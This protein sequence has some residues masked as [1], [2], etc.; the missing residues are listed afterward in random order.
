MAIGDIWASLNDKCW[1]ILDALHLGGVVDRFHLPPILLPII[2]LAVIAGLAFLM[3]FAGGTSLVEPGCGDGAC[4][5]PAGEDIISCPDDC[6]LEGDAAGNVRVEITGQIASEIEVSLNSGEGDLIQKRSGHSNTF[7]FEKVSS[8]MVFAH[9]RNTDNGNAVDTR[10]QPVTEDTVISVSLPQDF[11]SVSETAPAKGTLVVT[12]KSAGNEPLSGRISL[13][14]KGESYSLVSSNRIEGRLSIPIE[15]GKWYAIVAESSGYMIY[16]GRGDDFLAEAGKETKVDIKL[17][18]LTEEQLTQPVSLNVCVNDQNGLGVEGAV[19]AASL[20]GS[21]ISRQALSSGCVEFELTA[22]VPVV[23]STTGLPQDCVG[24]REE[25]TP[26]QGQAPL[27]LE[28]SCG[29][30]GRVRVKVVGANTVLTDTASITASY[31]GGEIIPGSGMANT[32]SLGEGGYT[33]FVSVEPMRHFSFTVANL[34]DYPIYESGEYSVDPLENLSITLNITPVPEQP[35]EY[36]FEF[37]GIAY[38][39]PVTVNSPFTVSISSIYYGD[40]DITATANLSAAV[41]GNNCTTETRTGALVASCIAPSKPGE[42]GLG[43][44]A[45]YGGAKGTLALGLSALLVGEPY[46]EL[47]PHLITDTQ[48]PIELDFDIKFNKTLLDQLDDSKVT[49][50]YD[51]GG[52]KVSELVLTGS[53]GWYSLAVSTPYPGDHR[54]EI[55]LT[56]VRGQTL[57]EQNFTVLFTSSA[58]TG[59]TVASLAR[60]VIL[61]PSEQF[62]VYA[63]IKKGS[64]EV[65]SL[66]NV[67]S[68]LKGESAQMAWDGGLHAYAA[69]FTAPS[70]EGIYM[71]PITLGSQAMRTQEIY[72]VDIS[73]PKSPACVINSCENVLDARACSYEFREKGMH[74]ETAIINCVKAS[75]FVASDVY[76]CLSP[77]AGRGD[78]K[79]DC[80][81]DSSDPP[82]MSKVLAKMPSQESL[83][84]YKYCGDMDNDGDVDN[85]DLTCLTNVIAS[86]WQGD[87]GT[88][89]CP[90]NM[91]G[92]FCTDILYGLPGDFDGNSQFTSADSAIMVKI[93]TAAMAGVTTPDTLLDV[94]DFDQNGR[95]D[96]ADKSCLYSIVGGGHIDSDCLEVYGFGCG[97]A[98]GDLNE[99]GTLDSMDEMLLKWIING[100]VDP[101]GCADLNGDDLVTEEDL[102]CLRG[103]MSGDQ[104]TI[105]EYCTNCIDEQTEFG[106][107]GAEF[108]NDGYDNNCNGEIDERCVCKDGTTCDKPWDIDGMIETNDG[109]F[110]F[111]TSWAGWGW[112][113]YTNEYPTSSSVIDIYSE[114][115]EASDFGKSMYNSCDESAICF[116]LCNGD[117]WW[118]RNPE[119][120]VELDSDSLTMQ[121]DEFPIPYDTSQFSCGA[122]LATIGVT[123]TGGF[124]CE[125]SRGETGRQDCT[126]DGSSGGCTVGSATHTLMT[127]TYDCQACCYSTDVCP[128]YDYPD[129]DQFFDDQPDCSL[130]LGDCS[131]FNGCKSCWHNPSVYGLITTTATDAN[132]PRNKA[133]VGYDFNSSKYKDCLERCMKGV[134]GCDGTA[135]ISDTATSAGTFALSSGATLT[136]P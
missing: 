66:I 93:V 33:E 45:E 4:D 133:A 28:V 21:A 14:L 60:P 9:V 48:S 20:T 37:S 117:L 136:I 82:L 109:A 12:L 34:S 100:R 24:A 108:C 46:F 18:A 105:D 56:E 135:T 15:A 8:S 63:T 67:Y 103:I 98:L 51:D 13:Y 32:L 40:T 81:L 91:K 10:P 41:A 113:P 72:V 104:A 86:K 94:A 115:V 124:C 69:S 77:D 16:D 95:I 27:T 57:Y 112:V 64:S 62:T 83:N 44:I 17:E 107:Y 49:I 106:R 52:L 92:G 126:I 3:L 68:D 54:A 1:P 11:F 38:P 129:F 53:N 75:L 74:T 118:Y 22:G 39:N 7:T 23:F 130:R 116:G 58:A 19:E 42:Y 120:G 78:W 85:D 2:L 89:V 121:F 87:N 29:A 101:V 35:P 65:A 84:E 111:H 132:C 110:C 96:Q 97:G 71:V 26:E 31:A 122:A 134:P 127:T 59:L 114:C 79:H 88:G 47:T 5:S 119:E 128:G 6:L 50:Y 70:S 55:K 36:E 125:P 61:K 80:K 30:A 102:L 90:A 43:L 25:I 76:L 131:G 99:D 123:G 73:R